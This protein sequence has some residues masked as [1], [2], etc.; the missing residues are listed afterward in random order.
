MNTS[1]RGIDL[2]K[3]HEGL[4]LRRYKDAAGY[5]TIGYG[6]LL[7]RGEDYGVITEAEA[8]ALLAKDIQAAEAVVRRATAA[9][10]E[11]YEFDAL[12]SLAFNLPAAFK[13][14]T[15]LHKKLNNRAKYKTAVSEFGRWIYAPVPVALPGLIKRRAEEALLFINKL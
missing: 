9:E 15:N 8:D 6:H 1:L 13:E 14:G 7:K 10:L 2:I 3:R 12:V 11:Q 4:R 5:A